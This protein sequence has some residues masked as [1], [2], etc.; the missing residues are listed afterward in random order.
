MKGPY[1]MFATLIRLRIK[2]P[3]L[4]ILTSRLRGCESIEGFYARQHLL[5]MIYMI[6][7]RNVN[8]SEIRCENPLRIAKTKF[9]ESLEEERLKSSWLMRIASDE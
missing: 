7:L 3:L 1:L 6:S 4:T 5:G 9:L 8:L 2:A